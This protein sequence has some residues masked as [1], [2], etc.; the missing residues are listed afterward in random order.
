[1]SARGRVL[2]PQAAI[3]ARTVR[4]SADWLFEPYWQGERLLAFVVRGAVSL[5]D[6][7]G[8]PADAAFPEVIGALERAVEADQAVVDLVW[9]DSWLPATPVEERTPV[10][11][12][13]DL[14]E[15]D[16]QTLLDVPLLERRRLLESVVVESDEVRITPAARA[17]I[18]AS[19]NAW[20]AQG[21]QATMAKHA[22]SRY[23]PGERNAEWIRIS[24]QHI[25]PT[26]VTGMLFGT[27]S[28]RGPQVTP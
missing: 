11:V 2:L 10:A 7:L 15:I 19:M 14:L 9:A 18:Q 20:R 6:Y 5:I 27:R 13:V 25:R 28:D 1:M 3:S 24:I 12:V 4:G 23:L 17:P 22:N 16:D 26:G 8:D 21:F